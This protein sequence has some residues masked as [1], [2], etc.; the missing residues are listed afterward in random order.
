[1]P[2]EPRRRPGRAGRRGV[3]RGG[4]RSLKARSPAAAAGRRA[5]TADRPTRRAGGSPVTAG[6]SADGGSAVGP[7]HRRESAP[8]PSEIV[9][10]A[11][12][13]PVRA[14]QGLSVRRPA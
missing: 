1:M 7:R 13:R 11:P 3:R 9:R 14:L 8:D 2:R 4:R 10:S 6:R 5:L 12:S